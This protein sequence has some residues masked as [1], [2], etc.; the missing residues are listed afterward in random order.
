MDKESSQGV[1]SKLTQGLPSPISVNQAMN[2][3][4]SHSASQKELPFGKALYLIQLL[5]EDH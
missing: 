4:L 1:H 5:P 3:F 2:P